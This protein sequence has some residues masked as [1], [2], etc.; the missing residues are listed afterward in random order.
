METLSPGGFSSFD[1]SP[2]HNLIHQG[3][4]MESADGNSLS[5]NAQFITLDKID[6]FDSN[7]K[8]ICVL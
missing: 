2:V 1:Q 7:D 6:F 4:F 3:I 5:G 8:V